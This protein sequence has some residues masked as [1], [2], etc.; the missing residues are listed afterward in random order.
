MVHTFAST[1]RFALVVSLLL[2]AM[3]AIA[4]D[5]QPDSTFNGIG[6]NLYTGTTNFNSVILDGSGGIPSGYFAAGGNEVVRVLA[7]GSLNPAFGGGDGIIT[8]TPS[9]G[10]LE[11]ATLILVN[12]GTQIAAFGTLTNGAAKQAVSYLISFDG[13]VVT[14][15]IYTEFANNTQI[16]HAIQLSDGKFLITGNNY[17][18][19]GQ[20]FWFVAR[21]KS[22]L[23]VDD[24]FVAAD[25]S[26]VGY[27]LVQIGDVVTNPTL[28]IANAVQVQ[29]VDGN[30]VLAGLAQ[31]AGGYGSNAFAALRLT[32]VGYGVGL[33][34]T[35][36]TDG[37]VLIERGYDLQ[38]YTTDA[39]IA[40]S[41]RLVMVG[42]LQS[43][44]ISTFYD[45][46]V[47]IRLNFDGSLDTENFNANFVP[48]TTVGLYA[49]EPGIFV[50]QSGQPNAA[51]GANAV[52][53]QQSTQ[54]G[55]L[56]DGKIIAVGSFVPVGVDPQ[57][58]AL[59]LLPDGTFDAT[60]GNGGV[61]S[62]PVVPYLGAVPAEVFD[63]V[64]DY[65]ARIV[66]AGTIDATGALAALSNGTPQSTNFLANLV[67]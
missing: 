36:G 14:E 50:Y 15:R 40:T 59:R 18:T 41:D 56:N 57:I 4:Q 25:A 10:T 23:T 54:L 20:V 49:G 21:L 67:Y 16:T 58:F 31:Q 63:V 61:A 19:A 38:G 39:R 37:K 2:S 48:S 43:R 5:G 11:I 1:T 42:K 65:T 7:N 66:M 64:L 13:S 22:D 3:G 60:F 44:D 17:A 27:V 45:A 34:V 55:F 33:D 24:S 12:N 62:V 6:F 35:Y 32:E 28:S 29:N 51:V 30:I 8:V 52:A 26:T 47:V 46:F 53:L 9:V